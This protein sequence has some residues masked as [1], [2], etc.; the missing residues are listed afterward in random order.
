[1]SHKATTVVVLSASSVRAP[2]SFTNHRVTWALG[3]KR[4]L[5]AMPPLLLLLLPLEDGGPLLVAFTTS[6][7]HWHAPSMK[8]LR[9]SLDLVDVRQ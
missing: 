4:R 9:T 5:E 1:V 8:Q 6:S 7:R 2:L 3:V